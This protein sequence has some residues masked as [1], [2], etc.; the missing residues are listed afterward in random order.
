MFWSPAVITLSVVWA[1]AAPAKASAAVRA[2]KRTFIFILLLSAGSNG[3]SCRNFREQQQRFARHDHAGR[4]AL[5]DTLGGVHPDLG[6]IGA[7]A[8]AVTLADVHRLGD[9]AP[10]DQVRTVRPGRRRRETCRVAA[11]MGA[12]ARGR[13]HGVGRRYQRAV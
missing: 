8:I 11:E 9:H 10:Q 1:A 7:D 5:G 2:S 4:A 6:P 12:K 13:R 3:T